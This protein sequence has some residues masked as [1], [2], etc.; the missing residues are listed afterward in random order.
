MK[1]IGN[2]SGDWELERIHI[3]PT[4]E[5]KLNGMARPLTFV[6]LVEALFEQ[7]RHGKVLDDLMCQHCEAI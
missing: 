4:E 5:C 3:N 1:I 7:R 6:E 2:F